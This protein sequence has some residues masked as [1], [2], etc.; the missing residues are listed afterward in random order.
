MQQLLVNQR[1]SKVDVDIARHWLADV[2]QQF[3]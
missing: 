3:S 1:D 2:D